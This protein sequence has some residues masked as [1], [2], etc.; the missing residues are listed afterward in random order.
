LHEMKIEKMSPRIA[1]MRCCLPLLLR[2]CMC[3][4][5]DFKVELEPGQQ[6]RR[7][8]PITKDDADRLKRFLAET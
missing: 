4:R 3:P 7:V 8:L 6:L 1:Q 2:C 5:F